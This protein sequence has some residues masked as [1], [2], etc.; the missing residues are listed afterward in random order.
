[1]FLKGVPELNFKLLRQSEGA[2]GPAAFLLADDA[3]IAERAQKALQ[4]GTPWCD[5]SRGMDRETVRDDGV[6]ESRMSDETSNRGF[7]HHYRSVML[8]EK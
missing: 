1:M 3:T 2:L 7:W 6:K 4:A 8:G 5:L